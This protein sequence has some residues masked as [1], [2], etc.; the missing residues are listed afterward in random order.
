MTNFIDL[1][2]AEWEEKY[3]PVRDKHGEVI[4]FDSADDALSFLPIPSRNAIWSYVTDSRFDY[5]LNG[6]RYINRIGFYATEVLWNESEYITV[7]VLGNSAEDNG[8]SDE[9]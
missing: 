8:E 9:V 5:V 3:R 1:T 7:D 2:F 6:I 4:L